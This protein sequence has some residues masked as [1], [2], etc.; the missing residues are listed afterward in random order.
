MKNTL[1]LIL[2]SCLLQSATA[3]QCTA[4]SSEGI[5]NPGIV[6]L[7]GYATPQLNPLTPNGTVLYSSENTLAFRADI[8]VTCLP[9][10]NN[11]FYG[12]MTSPESTYGT[13]PTNVAGVGVR[14]RAG[15]R[16]WFPVTNSIGNSTTSLSWV[17]AKMEIQFVK[18]GPITAGG[19]IQGEVA[20]IWLDNKSYQVVSF[21]V[22]GGIYIKPDVPTCATSAKQIRVAMSPSGNLSAGQ[23]HGVGTTTPERDFSI[24]LNCSGG[25]MGTST[26]V[27]AT[28]TDQ[29]SPGNRS[30]LLSLAP[31][32]N[33]SGLAVQIL[34]N[35]S[36]L[37]FGPDSSTAGTINQ[38][39]A[40]EVP[41]GQSTFDIPLTAHYL[42]TATSVKPGKANANATF[43]LSYQ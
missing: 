16:D 1:G 13:Y 26:R 41:A 31:D 22:R 37:A 20:G 35:G 30:N 21:V 38:W 15:T 27:F 40:G 34:R 36:P 39:M 3:S 5:T 6:Y 28:L 23:F 7:D 9:S 43:T 24:R 18:T 12:R 8:R 29:S 14:L 11:I 25:M 4:V 17:S 42:Q 33:A 10:I 19:V 32:S 2:F